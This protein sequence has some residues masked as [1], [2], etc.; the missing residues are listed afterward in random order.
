M[1]RVSA[2]RYVR[3]Q[4]EEPY[5]TVAKIMMMHI[6]PSKSNFDAEVRAPDIY[7][8][9]LRSFKVKLFPSS[10][11]NSYRIDYLALTLSQFNAPPSGVDLRQVQYYL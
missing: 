9:N 8:K 3:L 11:V 7:T 6:V 1:L 10:F 5:V 4:K 2:Y